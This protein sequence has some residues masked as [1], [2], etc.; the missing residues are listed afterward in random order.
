M[1]LF[2]LAVFSLCL[3]YFLT[4]VCIQFSRIAN[5]NL[6]FGMD[7]TKLYCDDDIDDDNNYMNLLIKNCAM[8]LFKLN[9]MITITFDKK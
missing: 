6:Q 1:L 8:C 2:I 5:L 7:V 4:M 9:N 3:I